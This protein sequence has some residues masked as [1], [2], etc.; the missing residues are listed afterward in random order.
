MCRNNHVGKAIHGSY[1]NNKKTENSVITLFEILI[2]SLFYGLFQQWL[3]PK[4]D[5]S[6]TFFLVFTALYSH[7]SLNQSRIDFPRTYSFGFRR[8][9]DTVSFQIQFANFAY[10]NRWVERTKALSRLFIC[11]QLILQVSKVE[12]SSRN[13]PLRRAFIIC[14]DPTADT[15]RFGFWVLTLFLRGSVKREII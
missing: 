2:I 7:K 5:H 9:I 15:N 14:Q 13:F 10:Q 6:V 3:T 1:N 8:R 11:A 12:N 4:S